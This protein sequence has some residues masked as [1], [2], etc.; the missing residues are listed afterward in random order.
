M[1]MTPVPISMVLVRAPTAASSGK[2]EA[3][4]RAIVVHAEIGAVGAQ[5]LGRFGQFDGLGQHV[6]GGTDGRAAFVG[7]MAEGQKADLLHGGTFPGKLA[8]TGR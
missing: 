5:F 1:S 8:L 6:G 2:G 3:S 7:P 4:W